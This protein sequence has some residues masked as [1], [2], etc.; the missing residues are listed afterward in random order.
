MSHQKAI[1]TEG[2]PKAIGPYSQ[3]IEADCGKMIFVS[4]QIPLDPKTGQLIGAG[5]SVDIGQQAERCLSSIEAIL[6]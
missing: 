2:A 5:E 4:G 3:G 1:Q 6:E